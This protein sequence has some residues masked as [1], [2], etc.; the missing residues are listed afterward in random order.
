MT[1]ENTEATKN[2]TVEAAEAE[3]VDAAEDQV[4]L[5]PEE[6]D[7]ARIAELEA[8]VAKLKDAY[9]R[10]HAE[11]ENVRKRAQSDIETR[12]KFAVQ[13]FAKDMLTV[14]DNL[15]RAL[16]VLP[17]DE[18]AMD[19]ATKNL[20]VGLKMTETGLAETLDRHN[21]KP[22]PGVG[23]P[24]DPHVHQAVQ[25]I[26]DTSVPAGT[27]VQVFQTGYVLNDRLLREAMVVVSRGGPKGEGAQP[28]GPGKTADIEC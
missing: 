25:E 21:V 11:M 23:S 16:E 26:E 13:N 1:N 4:E 20:T 6:Q 3:T 9:V 5:S 17:K 2:E 22:V 19:E 27:V 8:E 28:G 14:A 10:A 7:E 15:Q 18:A 24:F 12:T